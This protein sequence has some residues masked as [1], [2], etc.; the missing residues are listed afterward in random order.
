MLTPSKCIDI[1]MLLMENAV[2]IAPGSAFV[3]HPNGKI[4]TKI[5]EIVVRGISCNFGD[6]FLPGFKFVVSTNV[7]R[8]RDPVAA[9]PVLHLSTHYRSLPGSA[10]RTVFKLGN[11]SL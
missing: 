6:R 3:D 5:H 2:A 7:C 9:L 8:Q 11:R 1:Q 10:S 4:T